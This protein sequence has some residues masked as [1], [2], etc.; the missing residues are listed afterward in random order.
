[1]KMSVGMR[2]YGLPTSN[3]PVQKSEDEADVSCAKSRKLIT[4]IESLRLKTLTASCFASA[5]IRPLHRKSLNETRTR[6]VDAHGRPQAQ[7]RE[8]R[9]QQNCG[10]IP[11]ISSVEDEKEK[12][13]KKTHT[14]PQDPSLPAYK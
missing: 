2:I 8:G 5:R 9:L 7:F 4:G 6:M 14:T 3:S 11:G 12:Q 1:M 10:G 13:E